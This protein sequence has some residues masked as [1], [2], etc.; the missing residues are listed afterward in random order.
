LRAWDKRT[1]I[2]VMLIAVLAAFLSAACGVSGNHQNADAN[3]SR[4]R[5]RSESVATTDLRITTLEGGE[6]HLAEKRGRVVALYFMA[7]WCGTCIPEAQVWSEL[8]PAYRKRG[9]E[10]LMVSADPNDTPAAIVRFRRIAGI[11][12]LPWAIDRTGAVARSVEVRALDSTVLIDREGRVTFR[13]AVPTDPE[14]LRNELEKA[15]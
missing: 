2:G 10:L 8:Y 7:S 14:T 5:A 4:E 15:L 9:L 13:D 1:I 6:F 3:S 12:P 11:D